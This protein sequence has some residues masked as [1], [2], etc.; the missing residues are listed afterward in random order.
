[1]AYH[2]VNGADDGIKALIDSSATGTEI[3]KVS[4][5]F[6]GA[7]V[8]IGYRGYTDTFVT[9]TKCDGLPAEYTVAFEVA[10]N[11][12]IAENLSLQVTGSTGATAIQMLVRSI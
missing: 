5:A 1:M 8:S 3:V 4:G 2:E 9:Y 6:G 10:I 7:T 12:G 11:C